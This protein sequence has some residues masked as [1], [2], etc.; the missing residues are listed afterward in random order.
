M[1]AVCGKMTNLRCTT[2][3]L[4]R[5]FETH[6]TAAVTPSANTQTDALVTPL[7]ETIRNPSCESR[8]SSSRAKG[9]ISCR[10][11]WVVITAVGGLLQSQ[12]KL[13]F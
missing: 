7:R 8:H 2:V 1:D 12:P 10:G 9:D 11:L 13:L 6:T 5:H 4:S 3:Q